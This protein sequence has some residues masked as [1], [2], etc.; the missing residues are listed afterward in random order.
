MSININKLRAYEGQVLD[1]KEVKAICGY[2]PKTYILDTY[3]VNRY[4]KQAVWDSC[5]H[6]WLV[7]KVAR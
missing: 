7:L 1:T 2:S 6:K 3:I 5:P 4:I